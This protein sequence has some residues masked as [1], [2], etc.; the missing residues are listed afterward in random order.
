[1][2]YVNCRKVKNTIQSSFTLVVSF[3]VLALA[4]MSSC[5]KDGAGVGRCDLDNQIQTY[6]A[7][8]ETFLA[9]QNVTTCEQL[10]KAGIEYVRAAE[11][12]SLSHPSLVNSAK[13]AV[14]AFESLNCAVE[15]GD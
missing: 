10:K 2:K 9:T 15:F 1:M 13:E 7:A 12:C 14:A 6:Q 11:R 4:P 5:K 8:V 3:V